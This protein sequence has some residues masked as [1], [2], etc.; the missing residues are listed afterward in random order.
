MDKTVEG[1]RVVVDA[2]NL[3]PVIEGILFTRAEPVSISEI[4][5]I[6]DKDKA[7][8]RETIKELQTKLQAD[9]ETGLQ[10]IEV[11]GGYQL[12]TKPDISPYLDKLFENDGNKKGNLSKAALETLAIIAYKE[13]ITRVEIEEIRGVN[14]GG[15]INSLLKKEL[16][17]TKGRKEVAG[18][19]VLFGVTKKFLE[20]FG[21]NSTKEL[22]K[23]E[24]LE[25]IDSME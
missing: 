20:H 5:E 10:I 12:T 15:V 17:M 6:V 23:P 21:L 11:A 4:S 16:I 8:V 25:E 13:P 7:A 19:P 24:E 18:K 22:P 14:S 9:K 3:K 1:E 2:S